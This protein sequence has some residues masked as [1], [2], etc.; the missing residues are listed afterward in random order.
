M[1]TLLWIFHFLKSRRAEIQTSPISSLNWLRIL[2]LVF[3]Y[4]LHFHS[5]R[6]RGE[7]QNEL[8]YLIPIATKRIH[9]ENL[10]TVSENLCL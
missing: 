2:F 1:F 5:P 6:L 10:H 3:E 4:L 8:G 9:S 7:V